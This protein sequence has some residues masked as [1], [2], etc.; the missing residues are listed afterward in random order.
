MYASSQDTVDAEG[1]DLPLL[2][3]LTSSTPYA[4]IETGIV[5]TLLAAID[6]GFS[7]DWTR[8]GLVSQPTE[9]WIRNTIT[10]VGYFHFLCGSIAV[11]VTSSRKQP[12][13]PA[14][15]HT[16][17]IGGLGLFRVLTQTDATAV[18]FF[19]PGKKLAAFITD[20]IAGDYDETAINMQIDSYIKGN[21]VLMFSQTTCPFCKKAKKVLIEELG[22]KV[23][24]IELDEDKEVGYPI[25]AEL[26]KRTGST[27][28][29]KV[30]V[31]GEYI[32][33]CNDGGLGGIVPLNREGK[34]VPILQK[35]KALK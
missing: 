26:G 5:F 30:Y 19:N 14:L 24:V 20:K 28:V 18:R 23:K 6:G 15:M 3:K 8:Y 17:L 12:V 35:A 33:G 2:T 7:G 27:S 34:L 16:M 22:V 32:G 4:L 21:T 13:A 11:A 31:K 29:P 10:Q 9:E 1:A 25:R